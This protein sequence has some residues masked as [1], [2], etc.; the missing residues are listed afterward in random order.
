[1]WDPD[2]TVVQQL[3]NVETRYVGSLKTIHRDLEAWLAN[4]ISLVID[5]SE[6]PCTT[7]ILNPIYEN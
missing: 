5:T 1:M 3:H 6:T 7:G 4:N 2:G